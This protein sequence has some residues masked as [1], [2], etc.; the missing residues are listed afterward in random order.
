[1]E[2]NVQTQKKFH[3]AWIILVAMCGIMIGTM[4]TVSSCMGIF[5]PSVAEDLG[6]P[7]TAVALYLDRKSVV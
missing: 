3:Y 5:T 7:V 1:M 6:V 2:N 4:G